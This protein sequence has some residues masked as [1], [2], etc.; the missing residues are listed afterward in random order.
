[1]LSWNGAR[2]G[3]G[4]PPVFGKLLDYA[5]RLGFDEPIDYERFSADFEELRNSKI[6]IMPNM[7]P[8]KVFIRVN[9]EDSLIV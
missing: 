2:L 3:E 1:M 9:P 7:N 5:R 6:G 4:H 8:G